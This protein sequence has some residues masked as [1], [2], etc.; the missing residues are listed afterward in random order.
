MS[1]YKPGLDDERLVGE[2]LRALADDTDELEAPAAVEARLRAAFRG[3]G[4]APVVP[5]PWARPAAWK[6]VAALATAA[7]LVGAVYAWRT[8]HAERVASTRPTEPT[9]AA[10]ASVA[11]AATE[12]AR[13]VAAAV[14]R[15]LVT[16][17][18]RVADARPERP[19][20]RARSAPR[21]VRFEP[22]YPG[23]LLADLDA[24]HVVRLSV[25]RSSLAALGW[26]S[27]PGVGVRDRVELDAM[28]GPD[29]MTRA[30]RFIS[31]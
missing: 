4:A 9:I 11:P 3:E 25:P 2:A 5:A 20:R 18:L 22:L 14:E 27:R 6:W 1:R 26:P 8:D 16:R 21:I 24:V 12:V 30:V 29:G 19:V 15:P 23:D 31:Q 13:P 10:P 7:G 28:V 17:P